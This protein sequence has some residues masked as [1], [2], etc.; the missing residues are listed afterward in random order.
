METVALHR[1][2]AHSITTII[3]MTKRRWT[4]YWIMERNRIY[5]VENMSLKYFYSLSTLWTIMKTM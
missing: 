5:R 2:I 3:L 1:E 4:K